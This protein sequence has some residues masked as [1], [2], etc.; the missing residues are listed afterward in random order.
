MSIFTFEV[1]Q[2]LGEVAR[3]ETARV[4]VRVTSPER[5]RVARVGRLVAVKGR[6]ANEWVIGM[7]E[8]VWR[9]PALVEDMTEEPQEQADVEAVVQEENGVQLALV[10]TYR[11]REGKRV[12]FFTRAVLTLPT[13]DEAVYPIEEKALEDF[14][15]IISKEGKETA[16]DPLAVGVFTLDPKA[17]AFLDGNKLFQRHAALVGSTGTGKSWAVANL[18]EQA[19]K[20]PH[21]SAVVFDLHGEYKSLDFARHLR[22]A[23]PGDL[24]KAGGDVIFLPYWLLNWEEMQ[25]ILVD[26]SET[27]AHN[28]A[29]IVHDEM[30]AAK[31]RRLTDEG[32]KE[33]L[34]S[35]TVDSP[36]PFD[37]DAVQGAIKAKNEEMVPRTD[38]K[39]QRQGSFHGDFSRFLVRLTSKRA[40][41]RYGFMYQVPATWMEYESLHRLAEML[42]GHGGASKGVNP[43]I[44]VVDFS[45]VPSDIL[46]VI[47][48]LVA[49]LVFQIQF[50]GPQGESERHPVLL[51]CDEA[52]LYLPRLSEEANPLERRALDNFHRIAKEGRKYGVGMLVVS[53]RPADISTTILSQCNNFISLRL[54]NRE[55]QAVVRRLM[56]ESLEG[57]LEI[58]PAL[59]IGEAVVV[60][61]AILLPTRVKLWEPKCKP[62]SATIDFWRYWKREKVESDLV[63]AVENMRRQAR[64]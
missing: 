57:I 54:T 19:A 31:R 17:T 61:D 9:R 18:M 40:D 7:I 45:E 39:G 44:K 8:K 22:V 27:T 23:G 41:R 51:V 4:V 36:V 37:L 30:A 42:L 3:V 34:A 63:R 5:L 25:A 6:D 55:D 43:G 35:F 13:I 11:A 21:A 56:P 1:D 38:G 26:R 12:D 29:M 28:Q 47:V 33:V 10:G 52:H 50:W 62:L 15:A 49:R 32:K 59:D 20:L 64:Q 46:P 2:A 53:Q 16:E 24:A 58:L 14:M 48:A 60:G